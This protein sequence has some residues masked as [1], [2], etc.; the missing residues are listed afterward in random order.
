MN[1]SERQPGVSRVDRISEEGLRRLQKQ[2]QR[3]ARISEQVKQQWILRYGQAARD[4]FARYDRDHGT[5][6]D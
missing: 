6:G 5:G 2:L 3:G 4:L 1:G